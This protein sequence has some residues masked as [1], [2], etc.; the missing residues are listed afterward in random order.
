MKQGSVISVVLVTLAVAACGE[1]S[2]PGLE[3]WTDPVT[4]EESLFQT[5]NVDI[6]KLFVLDEAPD[7]LA[8]LERSGKLLVSYNEM[9]HYAAISLPNSESE[10]E[11]QVY[12]FDTNG[13]GVFNRVE[14]VSPGQ[15]F[16][17]NLVEGAWVPSLMEEVEEPAGK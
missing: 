3:T 7:G 15:S 9:R 17:I 14:L 16:V 2:G 8:L 11:A 13:D 6:W 4:G 1:A 10:G 5:Q 12:V